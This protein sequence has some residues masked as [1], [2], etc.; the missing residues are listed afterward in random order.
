MNPTDPN[1]GASSVELSVNG[2]GQSDFLWECSKS[3]FFSYDIYVDWQDDSGNFNEISHFV[4]QPEIV[5]V[6]RPIRHVTLQF[7]S[8]A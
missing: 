8:L 3:F 6:V 4:F 2:H 5:H 7:L 1:I